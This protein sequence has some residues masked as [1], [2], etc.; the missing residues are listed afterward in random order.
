MVE[1]NSESPRMTQAAEADASETGAG[2]S[3]V[4]EAQDRSTKNE[5]NGMVRYYEW[6]QDMTSAA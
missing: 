3:G 6:S 5:I 2:D 1:A 4:R